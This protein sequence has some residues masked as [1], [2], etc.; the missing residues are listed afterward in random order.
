[1]QE[2]GLPWEL[3]QQPVPGNRLILGAQSQ[4]PGASS[5]REGQVGPK[6]ADEVPVDSS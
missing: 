2:V 5:V 1:M 4:A 3:D 6:R